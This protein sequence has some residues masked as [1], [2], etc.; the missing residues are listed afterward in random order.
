MEL[1]YA[2]VILVLAIVV[3]FFLQRGSKQ[4]EQDFKSR[5]DHLSEEKESLQNE[6]IDHIRKLA[7][8]KAMLQSKE[9]QLRVQQEEL[10]NTRAQL[11]KDFQILANQILEEK[12]HRFTDVNKANM[13]AILK[14]LNEKLV[15]FRTKVEETYD[16]ESKQRFSLEERIKDLVAL[17]NQISEDANNLTRALK[18]NNKVQGNWGEMILESILEKSGLKKGEEYFLQE[19]ITDE[20]GKRVQNEQQKY[21]QPDVVVAYPGGRKIVIDSKVSLNAYVKYVEAQT[22]DVKN[23]AEKE[24]LVS[25]RQHIDELSQKSYQDYVD[26]LEF[27][28]MFV[29]NEP[30]YILAMQADSSLWDYAYRKRILLISPTNLIASLKVVADLWK[31]EYQSRNAI[32]IAKRGA[33]LYD[34]FAGFVDTLQDVGKN[35]ERSQK[36]YDKAFSQLK[37]GNG[38]LIRQAEMLK[39]LGVKAQKELPESD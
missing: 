16:K 7:E 22:D 13:E 28:M 32:E 8:S 6:K 11:N 38:N 3:I 2:A 24:H 4:R 33:A 1:V 9:E 12:T 21:M 20:N 34:K 17:N 5:I 35:I 19:F 25:I 27:V 14:P 36:A 30:A 39:E 26:S 15:E 37:D 31:R 10:L 18:G 29:P 23:V